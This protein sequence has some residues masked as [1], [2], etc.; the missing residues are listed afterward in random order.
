MQE[1]IK[2]QEVVNNRH[3][4]QKERKGDT[5][6]SSNQGRKEASGGSPETNKREHRRSPKSPK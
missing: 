4:I 2:K 6:R 5:T 1:E 3:E